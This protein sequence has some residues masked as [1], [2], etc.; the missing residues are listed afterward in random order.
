MSTEKANIAKQKPGE[1]SK[2]TTYTPRRVDLHCYGDKHGRA[3][4]LEQH[5]GDGLKDG[6]RHEEDCQRGVV[7]P[8]GESELLAQAGDV[9]VAD[10]GAVE[11]G[12]EVEE[13]E[14]GLL[15]WAMRE[16]GS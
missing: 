9:G 2:T 10:V 1:P 16:G 8:D 7:L 3:D 15:A 6:I 5:V 13:A 4:A 14:L 12:E 11:E